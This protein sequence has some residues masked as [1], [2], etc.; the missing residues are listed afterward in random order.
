MELPIVQYKRHRPGYLVSACLGL[1]VVCQACFWFAEDGVSSF[2][3][4]PFMIIGLIVSIRCCWLA[5]D[6]SVVLELNHEGI[7]YKRDLYGW[8]TLYSYAIRKEVG[9]ASLFMYLLLSFKEHKDPLEIQL[10]WIDD[11]ES[12]PEQMAAYAGVFK[13]NFDG[14]IKKEI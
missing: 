11:S 9:E 2:W 10:D 7:K 13:I 3:A 14:I 8:D 1:L 4:W 12:V 5:F 6:K